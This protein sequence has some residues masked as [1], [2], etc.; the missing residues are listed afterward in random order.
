MTLISQMVRAENHALFDASSHMTASG[1]PNMNAVS[2]TTKNGSHEAPLTSFEILH[3]L[4]FAPGLETRPIFAPF[5]SAMRHMPSPRELD[6]VVSEDL[7]RVNVQ[8][9]MTKLLHRVASAEN[10]PT[11]A[12][13]GA[14]AVLSEIRKAAHA[15][16]KTKGISPITRAHWIFIK[17]QARVKPNSASSGRGGH[18]HHGREDAC[19]AISFKDSLLLPRW[20]GHAASSSWHCAHSK[21]PELQTPA[22][23]AFK[24]RCC[25]GAATS[26]DQQY[27]DSYAEEDWASDLPTLG[28][29]PLFLSSL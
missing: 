21:H 29:T 4:C 27:Q 5:T 20:L 18:V 11:T 1:I 22:S 19:G 17:K 25:H 26:L 7:Y 12:K 13:I 9:Q 10:L 28:H 8:A 14:L 2:L 15:A 3:A 23:H 24:C 6:A 16:T